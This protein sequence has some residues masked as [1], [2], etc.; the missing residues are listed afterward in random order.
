MNY[1]F[2]YIYSLDSQG[3]LMEKNF[4]RRFECRFPSVKI[5]E[6]SPAI[7][8]KDMKGSVM[9]IWSAHG[10]GRFVFKDNQVKDIVVKNNCVALL[11]VDD[12]NNSTNM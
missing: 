4:S 6:N 7:M 2:A 1:L 10:E 3:T 12:D 11:Y 9:G 8:F 5:S